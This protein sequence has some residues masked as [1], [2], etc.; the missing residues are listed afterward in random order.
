MIYFCLYLVLSL[1]TDVQNTE[2]SDM[3]L[4]INS[5]SSGDLFL[6]AILDMVPRV[7]ETEVLILI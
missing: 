7:N 4:P 6:S 5:V 2:L 1:S 3:F